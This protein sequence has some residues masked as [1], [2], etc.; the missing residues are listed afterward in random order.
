MSRLLAVSVL[1]LASPLAVA[2]DGEPEANG[3]KM[4]A[5]L[6]DLQFEKNARLR[7]VA[8]VSLGEIV[9]QKRM[10][11]VLVREVAT[12]V[13][14]ALRNDAAPT[15]RGQ[16]VETLTQIVEIVLE[17]KG[18]DPTSIAIDLAES[19]RVEK[20]LEVKKRVAG[21]LGRFRKFGKQGVDPLI[22][23]LKDADAGLR[24][25][26]ADALG[27]IG[28]EARTAADELTKLL[29]DKDKGVRAAA[30]FALGRVEADDANKVAL[31]LAPL[32]AADPD[33][34]TRQEVVTS[35][36]LLKDRTTPT[37]KALGGGLSDKETEV[38]RRAAQAVIRLQTLPATAAV[39]EA[40]LEDALK[41]AVAGDADMKVRLEALRAL[42]LT[43]GDDSKDLIPFLGERLD[44]KAEKEFEVRVAVAE[45][46]GGLGL[47]GVA[48]LPA[49]RKAQTDAQIK[50]REAAQ[51]AVQ[52]ITKAA[53]PPPKKQ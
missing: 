44:A 18:G 38:R 25:T 41:K 6:D 42:V 17:E 51:R 43:F 29:A 7:R 13:G 53:A 47:N 5:W 16:A 26:A 30:A 28:E 52:R 10:Y 1:L 39:R 4:K 40:S 20:D 14:K 35:L 33:V 2:Q 23:C 19:L 8:I 11:P 27:R 24:Q 34:E 15:V 45:E 12:A 46:L 50:V 49:L 32:V 3:K 21:L 9:Q 36:G 37:L 22:V 31:A 48:A